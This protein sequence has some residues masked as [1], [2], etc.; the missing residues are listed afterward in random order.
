MTLGS[1]I[2]VMNVG[3]VEQVAAPLDL[4]DRPANVFV[5]GFIG[6][7]PMNMWPCTID[8]SRRTALHAGGIQ[9]RDL[10]VARLAREAVILGIRPHE[11][12]LTPVETSDSAGRV[13]IVEP[14]GS[15]T[16]AHVAVDGLPDGRVRIMIP[17]RAPIGAGDRIGFT[18]RRDRIH[19]F[20]AENGQ[21]I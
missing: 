21:R 3:S 4:Y 2:A 9:L 6:S 12:D 13:E 16:L 14:L 7:P 20:D 18:V 17:G 1:R 11:I 19:W 10:P 15:A 8:R 5:A